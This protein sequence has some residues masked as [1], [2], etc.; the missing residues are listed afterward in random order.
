MIENSVARDLHIFADRDQLYRVL[1]NLVLNA[2]QAGATKVV[3]MAQADAE[4]RSIEVPDNG[5]AVLAVRAS[6]S[7]LRAISCSVTAAMLNWREAARTA[8]HSCSGCRW[9]RNESVRVSGERCRLA[10]SSQGRLRI[11]RNSALRRNPGAFI[12]PTD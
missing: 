3:V 7:R 9:M 6:G 11:L 10:L 1:S 5:P 2:F 4:M 8:R 12:Y